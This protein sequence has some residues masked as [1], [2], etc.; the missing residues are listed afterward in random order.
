MEIGCTFMERDAFIRLFKEY[1]DIF[2]WTY[3]DLKIFDTMIIEDV[4]LLEQDLIPVQ[5]KLRKMHP[6]VEPMVKKELNKFLAT[7]IIFLVMHTKLGPSLNK[8]HMSFIRMII[9]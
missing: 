4:I 1:K 8:M 2:A 9:Q 5:Q 7:K 3:N 6:V